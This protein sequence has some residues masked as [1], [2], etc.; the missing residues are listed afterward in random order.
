M[1]SALPELR[2]LITETRRTGEAQ[3]ADLRGP[4][5]QPGRAPAVFRARVAPVGGGTVAV[6]LEDVSDTRRLEDVRRD[7]V[8]NVSH[9]LKT[10]SAR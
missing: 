5:F 9:E 8:A 1:L 10:P 7:F 2:S 4:L 6:L 3:E